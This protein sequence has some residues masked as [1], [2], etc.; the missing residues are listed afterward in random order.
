MKEYVWENK[1]RPTTVEGTILP[2]EVKKAFQAYVEAKELPN[3]IIA[4][5]SGVGKTTIALAAINEIGA[6]WIKINASLKRGI[7][8]VRDDLIQ[9]ASTMSMNGGRKYV[10]LDEADGILAGAQE[11]LRAFIEEYSMNCGF[12]LTCNNPLKI[13]PAIH[14]RCKLIEI[15]PSKDEFEALGRPFDK[16]LR[17]ILDKEGITY[18]RPSLVMLMKKYY[19]D[20]RQILIQVQ[21][22]AVKHKTIDTGI[23]SVKNDSIIEPVVK[24]IK[25]KNWTEMR[26][27]VGE[28]FSFLDEF[29]M[30][31]GSLIRIL[32]PLVE[33]KCV[34]DLVDL[35]NKYD[36]QNAFVMDKECNLTTFL[37]YVMREAIFK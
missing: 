19:P 30:F 33:E 7:D 22:Y 5:P 9:F 20:W 31:A 36:Y 10:I 26:K 15:R 11:S 37:T 32:E 28:N 13:I 2:E 3:L 6:D 1:Y 18:H 25:A 35:M 34:A 8:M 14:S 17:T 16:A 23:L 29:H 24:L 27:W 4:G 21:D 12:I